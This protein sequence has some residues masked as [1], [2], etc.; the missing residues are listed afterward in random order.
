MEGVT[1]LF[2]LLQAIKDD[3]LDFDDADMEAI[4][5]ELCKENIE[6]G[7]ITYGFKKIPGKESFDVAE[8]IRKE[9][10]FSLIANVEIKSFLHFGAVLILGSSDDFMKEIKNKLFNHIM[11]RSPEHQ[12]TAGQQS[13]RKLLGN[14]NAAVP[15]AI[16]NYELI[17]RSL[18]VNFLS[19]ALRKG[20]SLIQMLQSFQVKRDTSE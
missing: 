1:D 19:S 17:F 9:L 12:T 3:K 16:D 13:F 14:E 4:E 20:S 5:K 15:D 2:S 18:C 6:I 8:M 10:G 11:F 7:E